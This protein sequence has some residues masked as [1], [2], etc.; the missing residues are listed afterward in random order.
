M[1]ISAAVFVGGFG[2]WRDALKERAVGLRVGAGADTGTDVGPLIS[3][4]ACERAE[5]II[6]R[7]IE[8]VRSSNCENW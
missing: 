1:A 2:P 8:Q 7:S 4:E 3:Q 5:R 6:T